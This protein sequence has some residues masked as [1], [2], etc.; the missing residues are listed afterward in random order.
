MDADEDANGSGGGRSVGEGQRGSYLGRS[1]LVGEQNLNEKK[2][3]KS[4]L[5]GEDEGHGGPN[6]GRKSQIS[7]LKGE[8]GKLKSEKLS[9]KSRS[10]VASSLRSGRSFR[11]K[12]SVLQSLDCRESVFSDVECN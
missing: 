1:G 3:M 2:L 4:G 9:E 11:S 8:S 10:S 6:D 12:K 7:G 5:I